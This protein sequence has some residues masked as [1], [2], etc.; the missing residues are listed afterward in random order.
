MLFF[1]IKLLP[2]DEMYTPPMNIKVIDHRNFGRKPIVGI[3]V[4][5]R[6]SRFYIDPENE[7]F[8][9]SRLGILN[10]QFFIN[11]IYFNFIFLIF[12]SLF[13]KPSSNPRNA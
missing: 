12:F 4:I 1:F 5:K 6:L 9:V 13:R 8:N 11:L 2:K 7:I 10:R 3:H